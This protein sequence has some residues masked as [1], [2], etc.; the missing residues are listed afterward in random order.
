MKGGSLSS[1]P[2]GGSCAAR[3]AALM[4]AD[5][6]PTCPP[7]VP[8]WLLG[9]L[10][11]GMKT[12]TSTCTTGRWLRTTVTCAEIG[13]SR[14]RQAGCAAGRGTRPNAPARRPAGHL[15]VQIKL[16]GI[17]GGPP[18]MR[19]YKLPSHCPSLTLRCTFRDN[20][21][22]CRVSSTA[23]ARLS[24]APLWLGCRVVGSLSVVCLQHSGRRQTAH[25]F[26]GRQGAQR[27]KAAR[28]CGFAGCERA[29][30]SGAWPSI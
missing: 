5:T 15:T 29:W 17:S 8:S 9:G 16:N 4:R 7:P 1:S 18:Q 22:I 11:G 21:P 30:A 14:Q 20:R 13:P 26:A 25:V 23:Y 28:S 2:W 27:R 6:E 10:Q 12:L 19:A 24:A 3:P